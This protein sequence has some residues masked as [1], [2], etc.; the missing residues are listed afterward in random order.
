MILRHVLPNVIS[1]IMVAATLGI[2]TAIITES[3]LSFWVWGF[4]GF[5]DLGR[6]LST[7]WTRCR[8]IRGGWSCRARSSSLTVLS[9]NYIGDGLRDAMDPAFAGAERQRVRDPGRVSAAR[10]S[11]SR[12][13]RGRISSIGPSIRKLTG[14]VVRF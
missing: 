1:P 9:V 8:C 7:R 2:A 6:L 3:A 13:A 10:A 12:C 14:P 4:A 11:V 5:P